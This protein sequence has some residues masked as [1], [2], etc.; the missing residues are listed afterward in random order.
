MV[1]LDDPA[2]SVLFASTQIEANGVVVNV[3]AVTELN[4]ARAPQ[5]IP[6]CRIFR[7]LGE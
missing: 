5:S 3:R 4:V 6:K 1:D 2:I 7:D